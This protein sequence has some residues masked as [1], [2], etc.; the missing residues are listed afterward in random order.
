MKFSLPTPQF[1]RMR[2]P[3]S[4]PGFLNS[5]W[6]ALLALAILLLALDGFFLYRFGF[7]RA[8]PPAEDPKPALLR[9][10][11]AA[12]RKAAEAFE[13]RRARFAASPAAPPDLPNPFQ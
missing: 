1:F 2:F 3:F 5:A 8:A 11:E 13:S 12:I 4:L 6:W 7:G 9:L 10:D